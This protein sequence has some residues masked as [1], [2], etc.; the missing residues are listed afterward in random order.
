MRKTKIVCTIGPACNTKEMLLKMIAAGMNVARINMSHG[1]YDELEVLFATLKDAIKESGKNVSVLLDTKGPEVRV[2]VFKN[3]SANLREREEFSLYRE[4]T[5]GDENGVSISFPK[6]ID[7]FINDGEDAIGRELLL[8]DGIISLIVK[9]VTPEKIICTVNKGGALKNRKSINIPGYYIN[10]PYVSAQDRRDIEFG[11]THG[12]N[13]VAASFVR[14]H[15]DVR[16]LRDFIDSLGFEYVEIIAKIENQSGVDDM[17]NIIEYADGVMVARGDMGV[18]IPFIKLPEI[19]KTLI[20]KCVAKGKYVI[21]ATQMLESMTT[22][23]RPTRAEISDVANAVYDGTSAVMLSAE[24]AAGK[25]PVESVRALDAICTE[26]EMNGEFTA[27]HQYIEAN[28]DG[29]KNQIRRSIC[30]AAKDVADSVGAKAIIVE[31]ATGRVAR[32]MVR[33]RPEVPIIA[34]V[35]SPLVCKKLC[36][37]WGVTALMGE[38]K[39]TS[40]SITKQAMEKALST[41]LVHKGDT[42]VVLSSNRTCPTSSTDSLNVRIL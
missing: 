24:S 36:L 14:T 17:D 30:K 28:S 9:E 22:A 13:V 35:T 23:P 40:D 20:R 18:E 16:T 32:A 4:E 10:M 21:T 31:S 26:A 3:G 15:E 1:S 29:D 34:V 39:R 8:D 6:L 2:G 19:Q 38:E 27:L 42:V 11:L 37:N 7:I 5:E 25:Y 12:A 33:Y 41:G